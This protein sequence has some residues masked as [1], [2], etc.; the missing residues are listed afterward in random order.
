MKPNACDEAALELASDG[1][2]VYALT[3]TG[4]K[5]PWWRKLFDVLFG[6]VFGVAAMLKDAAL[7]SYLIGADDAWRLVTFG[8]DMTHQ[9][10]SVSD[11]LSSG[12][13]TSFACDGRVYQVV[14]RLR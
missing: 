7:R 2:S 10:R 3:L 13:L 4:V 9:S 1:E 5:Q 6:D 14:G 11:E 12:S 8:Q